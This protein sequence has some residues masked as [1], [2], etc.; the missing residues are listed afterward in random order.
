MSL[1]HA[2]LYSRCEVASSW[3]SIFWSCIFNGPLLLRP[4]PLGSR[5]IVIGLSVCVSVCT[6]GYLRHSTSELYGFNASGRG[7][8][9]LCRRC[10]M[11]HTSGFV[12][13]RCFLLM[14]PSAAWPHGSS[15]IAISRTG[16]HPCCAVLIASY[17]RQRPSP[18]L[19]EPLVQG[20]H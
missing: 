16:S 13:D 3:P 11:L 8:V 7:S 9:F 17:H 20:L 14:Y 6:R 19:D 15:L 2:A 5:S 10:D 12:D 18:R 1:K 4:T